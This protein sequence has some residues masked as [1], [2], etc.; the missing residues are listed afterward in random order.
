MWGLAATSRPQ[1]GLPLFHLLHPWH[2]VS[3]LYPKLLPTQRRY[4]VYGPAICLL[5]PESLPPKLCCTVE[6]LCLAS[7]PLRARR[8][9]HVSDV[10]P[11]QGRGQALH[12]LHN[13]TSIA[14]KGTSLCLKRGLWNMVQLRVCQWRKD[15]A[16]HSRHFMESLESERYLR[17]TALV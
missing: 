14:P 15:L 1:R 9:V 17:A 5:L 13:T 11:L 10:R 4:S 3:A 7:L 8:L 12:A 16:L 2:R 6:T